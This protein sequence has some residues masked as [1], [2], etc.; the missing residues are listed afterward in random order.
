MADKRISQLV[1]RTDIANND[2]VPIVANGASTTNKATISSIQEFM[3]ENLDLGVTSVGISLGTTG[4]DVNV[5]GSPIT[6]SG[7]ITINFPTAS[8][9]NRGLLSSAD[10]TTFNN[11]QAAGNYVTTDT[12]QTITGEK[13]FS[14]SSLKLAAN[15][16]ANAVVLRNVSGTTGS[17]AS[18]TTLGFNGSNNIFVSTQSK[19]GFILDF[20]N[21]VSNR[22]Y[23]LKDASGTLA[24]TSDIT[25]ALTGFV[26][27]DTAQSITGTKTFTNSILLKN[28][29]SLAGLV[30]QSFSSNALE[31][32]AT[33]SGTT[34]YSSITFPA[35]A[36]NWN[37]PN[38]SGTIALTSDLAGYVTLGT[39]Q[40]ITGQKTFSTS[41]GSDTAII[42]HGSGSG[43]A[44][45]ITKG[46]NG[47]G[48]R[49]AK[50]S[51]SGNAVTITGG[52]LSAEAATL[53]GAL[54]GTSASFTG[55]AISTTNLGFENNN[56]SQAGFVA[57]YTGTGAI[58]VSLSTYANT[59]AI[60]DETNSRFIIS[61][62][63][64]TQALSFTGAASFSSSVTAGGA[65]RVSGG[66]TFTQGEIEFT[67]TASGGQLGIF[68]NQGTSTTLFFDHRATGNTGQFSFRNGTGGANTLMFLSGG[69]N[70]GIG[71]ASPSEK[72][73]V[74]GTGNQY[75]KVSATDGSN[76]GIRM[77]AVGSREFAIFSDGALRFYDFTAATD[78]MRITSVGNTQPGAD[79]AYSLGVSGT[80][81]SAVWAANGTIQT[82]DEREKKDI[83]DSDL[84][85]DLITKL[86]PVSFKWKVG[87]NVVS[88]EVV[89]DEEGNPILD[90]EGNEKTESVL[91][92]REGKRTHYGLIA[93]E[94]EEVLDGKDFGGFI[95]DE[96]TD[97]KGLRY[98]QF[99]PLLIKSIQ[100]LNDKIAILESKLK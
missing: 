9:T 60:Y 23:T 76:A 8:A 27:L 97:T 10:W 46:G 35:G 25:N 95:H 65:L 92:P 57:N 37:L 85:L 26:T 80:R 32:G 93:Q 52:L 55:K 33:I 20:S 77:N 54:N 78:R 53:T 63:T 4:T 5:T 75:I 72:L 68:S 45:N 79:N 50:T 88:S 40:T 49:V 22:I 34:Y 14:G 47:E 94:V 99:V 96:E 64:S 70:V 56:A 90:E 66:S 48:L 81:W 43:I 3:Q 41:G 67:S 86:R 89:K 58:K 69:G 2:V 31:V 74:S 98:D 44:L 29:P 16:T 62:N 17:D 82:S 30:L 71:T 13:T 28:S 100:E 91:T 7:N 87:Q 11:K 61:Q 84:G 24:F 12:T 18:A 21:S 19:G 36:Q 51:G 38:A 15:G 73:E 39:T 1:A 83:V 59:F 6:T 42:N